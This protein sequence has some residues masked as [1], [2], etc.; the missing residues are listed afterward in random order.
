[1]VLERGTLIHLMTKQNPSE[2]V[3]M[4]FVIDKLHEVAQDEKSMGTP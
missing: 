2:R 4:A 1:M 3:K